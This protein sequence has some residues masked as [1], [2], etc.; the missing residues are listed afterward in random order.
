MILFSVLSISGDVSSLATTAATREM[1]Q[2]DE[3]H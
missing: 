2:R 1:I 3:L